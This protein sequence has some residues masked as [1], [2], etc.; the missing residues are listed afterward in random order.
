MTVVALSSAAVALAALGLVVYLTRKMAS[1]FHD[2]AISQMEANDARA[3]LKLIDQERQTL[4]E[5]LRRK[6]I[7]LGASHDNRKRIE[8]ERDTAIEQLVKARPGAAVAGIN[9]ELRKLPYLGKNPLPAAVPAP[10]DPRQ[11]TVHGA[12]GPSGIPGDKGP[13][14]KP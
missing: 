8:K 5:A 11:G 1:V 10:G 13:G 3:Q 9:D 7:E 2:R 4:V 14:R 6:E 12:T